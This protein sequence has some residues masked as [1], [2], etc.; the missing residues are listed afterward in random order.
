TL[1]AKLLFGSAFKAPSPVLLYAIPA[2]S[3]DVVGNP[4]LEPQFVRTG[5]LEVG[6]E[7]REFLS[8]SSDVAYS[9]LTDK[10]EFV[11]QGL[12][13]VARN[14]ARAATLSWETLAELKHRS[15]G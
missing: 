6:W 4:G 15:L 3:G 8:L 1:H 5:E 10:T 11:Q 14:L 7:P 12:N 9:V 2:A 13:Q